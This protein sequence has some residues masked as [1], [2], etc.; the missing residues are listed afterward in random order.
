M[1]NTDLSTTQIGFDDTNSA[2]EW[3]EC[4]EKVQSLYKVD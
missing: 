3:Q 2:L 1:S 4:L